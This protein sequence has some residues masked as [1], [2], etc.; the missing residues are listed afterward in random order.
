MADNADAV[1]DGWQPGQ[2]LDVFEA[3]RSAV[4]RSA[5][6]ALFGPAMAGH[7]DFLG[8]QLQPLMDLTHRLPQV[9]RVEQVLRTPAWRCAMA[10]KARVDALICAEVSRA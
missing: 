6:E 9:L 1:I 7:A 5:I 3:L 8:D 10:A 4:R 2:T